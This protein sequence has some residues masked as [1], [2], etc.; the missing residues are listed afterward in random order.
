MILIDPI[1]G[2]EVE[3]VTD[4]ATQHLMRHGYKPKVDEPAPKPKRA[5]T[6]KRTAKKE[7]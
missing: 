5:T 4:E 3:T 6:R 2:C 1:T 7:Q